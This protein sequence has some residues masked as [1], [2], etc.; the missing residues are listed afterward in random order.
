MQASQNWDCYLQEAQKGKRQNALR[1]CPFIKT[2]ADA[3]LKHDE[4]LPQYRQLEI[5]HELGEHPV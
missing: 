5:L 2:K 3:H 1:H 4:L